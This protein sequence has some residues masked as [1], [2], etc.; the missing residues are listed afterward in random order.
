MQS[1]G[2]QAI[3]RATNYSSLKYKDALRD[4]DQT[5]MRSLS[6]ILRSDNS[7]PDFTAF[8]DKNA[9]KIGKLPSLD[10]HAI[11]PLEQYNMP[12]EMKQENSMT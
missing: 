7:I 11:Q 5:E 2:N 1:F 12:I 6:Q 10:C 9:F 4:K 3:L 8:L